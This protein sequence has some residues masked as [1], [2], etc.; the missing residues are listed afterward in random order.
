MKISSSQKVQKHTAVTAYLDGKAFNIEGP[1][2]SGSDQFQQSAANDPGLSLSVVGRR[3]APTKQKNRALACYAAAGAIVAGGVVAGLMTEPGL[4][5]VIAATSLPAI[6]LGYKQMKAATASPN[7]APPELKTES[8]AQKVLSDSLKAQKAANPQARQVAYLSGHGNH[9]EVAGFKHKALAEVLQG[10]PVDMT[11][12]DACLCSQLEVVSE[13]APFAG[14]I[15]SS[16]DIVPNEGLPIE[17]L[18]DAEHA[19]GQMFEECV[20]A[21]VSASLIDSKAVKTKLLPALDTLGKDLAEGLQ[22][23]QSSTI[24]AALKAS[25]S[26]EHVGERVDMRS[27]LAQLKERGLAPE[28]VDGAIA[29]F[30]QSIL[31]HH[32]TPLTFR[33]DSKK[34]D[35]LPPGWT[36]F[37]SSLGKKIKVSH[38]ALL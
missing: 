24:K 37:L 3:V 27:F 19:P 13:L 23:D 8:Q 30:D 38:L 5:A 4:G 17:K 31:R 9:K 10:S 34:N 21:T 33:L 28:S 20:D 25:E 15:I 11:I 22:S 1:V 16:A 18:F 26:P 7:F 35:S 2:M 12:L 14:L 32:R 6:L 36:S 29:A